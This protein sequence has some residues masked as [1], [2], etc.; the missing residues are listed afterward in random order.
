M[1]NIVL[2]HLADTSLFGFKDLRV[3]TRFPEWTA[4]T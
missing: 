4:E 2:S 1:Q 3:G